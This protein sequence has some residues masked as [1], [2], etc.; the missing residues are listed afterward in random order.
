M[1]NRAPAPHMLPAPVQAA[2]AVVP[3]GAYPKLNMTNIRILAAALTLAALAACHKDEPPLEAGA[4][5]SI[6][7]HVRVLDADVLV[8]DGRH[9]RLANA[10]APESLLH[11]RCWAESLASDRAAGYVKTLV[12]RGRTYAFRLTGDTD[13]YGRAYGLMTIDG[14]DLGDTL[15]GAG[16]ASR[17]STPRFDWCG[18]ISQKAQ[19]A[20]RISSLYNLAG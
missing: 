18:P 4:P 19:G 2:R 16:L 13:D 15:Y 14:A 3:G 6:T 17:P 8:I 11:A 10:Y 20:P 9:V 5:A 7:A 12:E 1:D